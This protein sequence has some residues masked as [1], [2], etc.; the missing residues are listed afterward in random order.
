MIQLIKSGEK[1]LKKEIKIQQG[2]KILAVA[3]TFEPAVRHFVDEHEVGVDPGATV[4]QGRGHFHSLGEITGPNGGGE[5]VLGVIGPADGLVGGL[6]LGDGDNR[7]EDLVLHNLILVMGPGENGRLKEEP[8]SGGGG[9][10][11]DG[12]DVLVFGGPGHVAP[13]AVAVGGGDERAQFILLV[14]GLVVFE[15]R[16]GFT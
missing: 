9:A 4:T 11:G 1:M 14:L 16:D 8:F 2:G 12:L 6:E 13:D 7:A 3:G 15:G 5:A 10:T